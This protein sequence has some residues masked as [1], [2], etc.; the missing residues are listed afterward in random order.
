MLIIFNTCYLLQYNYGYRIMN[1][2]DSFE[3]SEQY[4]ESIHSKLIVRY[5]LK[6][7]FEVHNMKNKCIKFAFINNNN[8]F[9]LKLVLII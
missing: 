4:F 9:R 5:L 1:P 2:D 6:N 8:L 3:D 7:T